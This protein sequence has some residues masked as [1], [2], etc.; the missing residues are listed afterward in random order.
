[1]LYVEPLPRVPNSQVPSLIIPAMPSKSL[2][3]DRPFPNSYWVEPGRLLAGEHPAGIDPLDTRARLRQLLACGVT[4]FIDLTR[5]S[6]MEPYAPLLTELATEPIQHHRF[7][8]PDHSIPE[9][10]QV[11]VDALN[12]IDA[13]HRRAECVYVHCR[14]GIGRTGM[15]VA[16]WLMRQGLDNTQAF[17]RLQLL[18]QA[19]ARSVRWP[20][21]PETDEQIE[22]VRSWREPAQSGSRERAEGALI[23]LVLADSIA[24]WVKVGAL[25]PK[26]DPSVELRLPD[27]LPA[28]AGLTLAALESLLVRGQHDPL[29]QL[30]R[31]LAWTRAAQAD[32]RIT[33]PD[34]LKRALAAWQW[35][36]KTYAGSHDPRN[37]D[38]HSVARSLA[39]A[40]CF[41]RDG[42]RTVELAAEL[43]RTTQQAPVVLDV[44]RAFTALLLEVLNGTAIETITSGSGPVAAALTQYLKKLEVAEVVQRRASYRK[45]DGSAPAVLDAALDTLSGDPEFAA[46]VQHLA[47]RGTP[48]AAALFGA[49]HGAAHGVGA[50]PPAWRRSLPQQALLSKLIAGLPSP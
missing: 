27:V 7:A 35:S 43:S 12:A 36:R 44:C 8:I 50:L 48:T 13:A 6:E 2:N 42:E 38:A 4:T 31:Y 17:D 16:T 30:E 9:R 15:L 46:G 21:V 20:V 3:L 41:P 23:G 40:L 29:D 24:S 33:I 49:L 26:L 34:A 32:A 22:Y 5:E 19:C 14:A 18:W 28:D 45:R 10:P 37:L 47:L 11:I 25:D 1:M 39:A